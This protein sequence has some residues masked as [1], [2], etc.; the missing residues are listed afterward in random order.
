MG[1]AKTLW[2]ESQERGW[3]A[4]G[5]HV[6]A[7]CFED[8]YLK[9]V[10]EGAAIENQCDYCG[11]ESEEPIAAPL[12]AVMEPIARALFRN[13]AEP[14]GASLPRDSGEWVGEERITDTYDALCSLPLNCDGD[15]FE[16]IAQSFHNHAWYPC[17]GGFWLGMHRNV[18]LGY[19]WDSFVDLV[20]HTSRYFFATSESGEARGE[21][22]RLQLLEEIGSMAESL[23]LMQAIPV[24]TPLFRVRKSETGVTYTTFEEVGP[25]PRGTA[26]AGRMNPAGISY[27]YLALEDRT[28]IAEILNK[29]PATAV[30]ASFLVKREIRVLDLT[31]LPAAPS[32]FTE[33]EYGTRETIAFLERFIETITAP[34]TRDGREHIDYV[35]SQVVSEFLAQVLETD[36][37]KKLDGVVYPSAVLPGG[38]NLVIFPPG[39]DRTSFADFVDMVEIRELDARDWPTL[40]Y[41]LGRPE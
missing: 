36:D 4:P 30:L 15:L 6:C 41:L 33:D 17:A 37:G 14:G 18:E 27:F 19:S 11:A 13:F 26:S 28:A 2:M 8:E 10:V 23:G 20:K 9:S 3:D 5:K 22:T 29:P 21:P 16:D 25:P 38:R 39:D 1:L 34:V 35:P 31:K 7:E 12:A 40:Y 32:V 24:G